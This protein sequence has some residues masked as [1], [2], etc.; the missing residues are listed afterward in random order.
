MIDNKI[1]VNAIHSAED[2]RQTRLNAVLIDVKGR[3]GHTQVGSV[4]I[5]GVDRKSVNAWQKKTKQW[6]CSNLTK[7]T[8][9]PNFLL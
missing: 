8:N 5:Y 1:G 4:I 7:V 3:P 2:K 9:K 6:K